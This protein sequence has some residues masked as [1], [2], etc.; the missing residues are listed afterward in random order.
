MAASSFPTHSSPSHF[1]SR[2]KTLPI[3]G[4]HRGQTCKPQGPPWYPAG[5]GKLILLITPKGGSRPPPHPGL[6]LLA[7]DSSAQDCDIPAQAGGQSHLYAMSFL[8]LLELPTSELVVGTYLCWGTWSFHS[9]SQRYI[10][11]KGKAGGRPG[12]LTPATHPQ[13]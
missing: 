10:R 13:T 11:A 12:L 6:F 3:D 5:H 7:Q 2:L 8:N 4:H 1:H 9:G